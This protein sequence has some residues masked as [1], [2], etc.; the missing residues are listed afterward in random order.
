MKKLLIPIIALGCITSCAN[1]NEDASTSSATEN[2]EGKVTLKKEKTTKEELNYR[3]DTIELIS[4]E[5]AESMKEESDDD[6]E[7]YEDEYYEDEYYD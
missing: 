7:Y 3:L 6:D 4:P 1:K 5:N 2:E